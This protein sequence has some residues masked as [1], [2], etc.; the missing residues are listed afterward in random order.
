MQFG[1]ADPVLISALTSRPPGRG[2]FKAPSDN[3]C[4]DLQHQRITQGLISK[5][6][7]VQEE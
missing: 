7:A 5:R 2:S 4:V 1:S 3:R 6:N